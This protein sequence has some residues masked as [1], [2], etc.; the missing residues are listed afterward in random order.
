MAQCCQTRLT[1]LV[2]FRYVVIN[3]SENGLKRIIQFKLKSLS[4]TCYNEPRKHKPVA[5]ISRLQ[6]WIRTV[7]RA[8]LVVL[9]FRKL[10]DTDTVGEVSGYA[11]RV[12]MR[13]VRVVARGRRANHA[14]SRSKLRAAAVARLCRPA[15]AKPR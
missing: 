10:S 3:R 4:L 6:G 8:V 12:A 11:A 14:A 5:M 7:S 2:R 1:E 13:E 9:P 15:L